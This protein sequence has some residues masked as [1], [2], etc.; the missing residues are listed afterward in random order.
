MLIILIIIDKVFMNYC[1]L[2]CLC[3]MLIWFF[4]VYVNDVWCMCL[5]ILFDCIVI[6][7][8]IIVYNFVYN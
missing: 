3:F 5:Y 8:F 4:F 6:Y 1:V 7:I 2:K